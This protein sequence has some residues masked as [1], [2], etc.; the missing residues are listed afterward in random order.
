MESAPR[1]HSPP[2]R[3]AEVKGLTTPC[4][5]KGGD[6]HAHVLL[7]STIN[8]QSLH[9]GQFGNTDQRHAFSDPAAPLLEMR[10][11]AVRTRSRKDPG[12]VVPKNNKESAV[13]FTWDTYDTAG[14]RRGELEPGTRGYGNGVPETLQSGQ[15]QRSRSK[16]AVQPAASP[17]S[18]WMQTRETGA[19]GRGGARIFITRFVA[20]PQF[21]PCEHLRY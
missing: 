14:G 13:P 4:A 16:T 5:G 20:A 3:L 6:R 7:S 9:G 15:A 19:V 12:G 8:P 21:E 11:P 2:G 18:L 1:H 17:R 10:R